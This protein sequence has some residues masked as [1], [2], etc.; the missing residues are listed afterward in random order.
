MSPT[1]RLRFLLA[2][3]GI[4]FVLMVGVSRYLSRTVRPGRMESR[5]VS[6][7]RTADVLPPA[8]AQA[9]P[10]G[11]IDLSFYKALGRPAGGTQASPPQENVP[12][13]DEDRARGGAY[14]VLAL[15]TK[16]E[17]QARRLKERLAGR[18]VTATIAVGRLGDA[19]VYRVLI[20]RYRDRAAAEALARRL[21][22]EQGLNPWVLRESE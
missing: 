17:A 6:S 5:E 7:R 1:G 15:A 20:G 14:V 12:S 11:P 4:L 2:G 3:A 16:D 9:G 8:L 18:G 22:S 10:D 21:R 19:P 13:A